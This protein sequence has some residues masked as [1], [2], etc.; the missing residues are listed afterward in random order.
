MAHLVAM[1]VTHERLESRTGGV[2][3]ALRRCALSSGYAQPWGGSWAYA[4]PPFFP[5]AE[6]LMRTSHRGS[7][8]FVSPRKPPVKEEWIEEQNQGRLSV[9]CVRLTITSYLIGV[10]TI[11]TGAGTAAGTG[12]GAGTPVCVPV[13]VAVGSGTPETPNTVNRGPQASC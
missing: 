5:L 3:S 10:G 6:Y 2:S 7:P 11:G 1:R 9:V 4:H 13:P 12:A 8:S